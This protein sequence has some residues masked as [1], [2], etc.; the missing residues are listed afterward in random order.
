VTSPARTLLD[1]ASLVH[2]RQLEAAINEA[3]KQGLVDPETLLAE[4]DS[5]RGIAGVPALRRVLDRHTFALTDSE[6]E[7][8]FLR[9]VWQAKLPR[10]ETQQWVN[11]FRVD[12]LWPALGLVVE[13]DGLR[14]HR[15]AAQQTKDRHR[16]Q[17]LTTAGFVVLRFTHAQVRF[18]AAHVV[19]TLRAV[20]SE[21]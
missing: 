14:Y 4:L 5:H 21:S 3:D 16:D 12:F 6:L 20:L 11:G 1:L 9:L 2:P 19:A 17:T 8:C 10:P 7:R 18:D 13:T 15:T